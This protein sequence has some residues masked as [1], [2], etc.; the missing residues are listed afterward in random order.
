MKFFLSRIAISFL[1]FCVIQSYAQSTNVHPIQVPGLITTANQLNNTGMVKQQSSTHHYIYLAISADHIDKLYPILKNNLPF[2]MKHCLRKDRNTI[3]AHITLYEP[4]NINPA[5]WTKIQ[6]LLLGK[7]FKFTAKGANIL[8]MKKRK[9]REYVYET[10]YV[11]NVS[12]PK[13]KQTLEMI[14]PNDPY[15]KDLHYSIAVSRRIQGRC[16]Y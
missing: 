14:D 10:W 7:S 2:I 9:G 4:E 8:F 13:L 12:A 16:Y 11:I 5:M 1:C 3:G 15:I 6:K